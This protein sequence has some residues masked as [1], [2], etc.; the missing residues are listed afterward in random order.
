MN[1]KLKPQFVLLLLLIIFCSLSESYVVLRL[2]AGPGIQELKHVQNNFVRERRN[3][4]AYEDRLRRS[5][6]INHM[7]KQ[8]IL[9]LSQWWSEDDTDSQNSY[10]F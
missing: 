9:G 6:S 10:Y 4:A 5:N 8:P 3:S 1:F 2:R 7:L